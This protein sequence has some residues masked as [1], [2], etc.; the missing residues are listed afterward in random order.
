MDFIFGITEGRKVQGSL[1]GRKTER[2]TQHQRPRGGT[3]LV[4]RH[5]SVVVL[6][7][8]Q[9]QGLPQAA[10]RQRRSQTDQT[11]LNSAPG[12]VLDVFS[13]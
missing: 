8:D 9:W 4:R 13:T 2:Q 12:S 6:Q 11:T 7:V 5:G 1:A 10:R 3:E